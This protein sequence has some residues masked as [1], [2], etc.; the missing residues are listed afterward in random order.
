M[1]IILNGERREISE[2]MSVL[3]LIQQLRLPADRLA[4]EFNLQIIKREQ[5]AH[6]A[7]K[8][9]DRLELVQFVGGGGSFRDDGGV[10]S[11]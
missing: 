9:D 5:W 10:M 4:V 3:E 6:C 1:E 7:L 11:L 8:Q 2:G